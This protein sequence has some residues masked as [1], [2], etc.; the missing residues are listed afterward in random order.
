MV[1]H[2]EMMQVYGGR[3]LPITSHPPSANPSLP[4]SHL[5]LT[6]SRQQTSPG[7]SPPIEA[8]AH[9]PL[10]LQPLYSLGGPAP[11]QPPPYPGHLLPSPSQPWPL[12]PGSGLEGRGGLKRGREEVGVGLPVHYHSQPPSPHTYH[13]SFLGQPQPPASSSQPQPLLQHS[14]AKPPSSSLQQP[15]YPRSQAQPLPQPWPPV[16]RSGAWPR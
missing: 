15:P 6:L 7:P 3:H 14:Q 16:P 2:R 4:S 12:V 8:S 5:P 1:Y 13:P 9:L 10:Y 11:T